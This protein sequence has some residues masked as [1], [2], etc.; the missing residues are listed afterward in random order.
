LGDPGKLEADGKGGYGC[1]VLFIGRQFLQDGL[2]A[3]VIS[4]IQE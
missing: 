4:E 3:V 1:F 2:G